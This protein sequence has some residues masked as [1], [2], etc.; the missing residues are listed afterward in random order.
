MVMMAAGSTFPIV[1]LVLCVVIYNSCHCNGF[2]TNTLRLADD[3]TTIRKRQDR[4]ITQGRN[5]NYCKSCNRPLPQCLCE[6]LPEDKIGLETKVLVLQHPVEFRRKTISTVPLLKLVLDQCHVLVGRSFD[7]EL[8]TIINQACNEGRIPLLLF[9]GP[10]ATVLEDT[11]AMEQLQAANYKSSDAKREQGPAKYLLIIVDGT[12]TQAK[13]MVRNSPAL[14]QKCNPIQFTGTD[15]LSIY[16]A[17]RKQ[18]D[19]HC[20]STLE[21]CVRTLKLLEPENAKTDEASKHLLDS[22]RSMIFTQLKYEEIHLQ[23]NP[24]LI[25]NSLKL[26]AKKE[27]QKNILSTTNISGIEGHTNAVDNEIERLPNGYRLRPLLESDAEF[28]DSRWPYRSK[29]SLVMI[30][31]QI[32]ADNVNATRTGYSSCLG[33]EHRGKLVGCVMRHTNGSIGILHV[34]EDHRRRRLGEI[35]LSSATKALQQKNDPTYA[36]ILEGNAASEA[37]FTKMG[38]EKIYSGKK[39]TGKRRAKRLWECKGSG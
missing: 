33:I 36:F 24:D 12:W 38:W 3:H 31:K 9:P 35:L 4:S 27:R 30:R 13:R 39:G 2:S 37:L 28:V 20:L 17:I 10:R 26:K 8:E 21:S 5:R 29:K 34:D 14:M 25:R 7:V 19:T 15:D 22:L 32:I 11:N 23:K 1:L 18:P 16:D 6:H